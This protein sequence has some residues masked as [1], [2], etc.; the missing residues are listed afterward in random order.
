MGIKRGL[1][2]R[3][4]IVASLK[5]FLTSEAEKLRSEQSEAVSKREE[6]VASVE[7]LIAEMKE[8]L[9]QADTERVLM[10]DESPIRVGERGLG[11][12]EVP[13]LTIG[14]GTREVRVKPVARVVS[15]PLRATAMM[16]VP[17]AYGRVDMTNGLDRYLI[18][19]VEKEA[20][21]RWTIVEQDGP[22]VEPFNRKSF[23]SAFQRLLE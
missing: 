15:A 4:S 18:F 3:R 9:G 1:E 11:T 13:A 23:E 20:A 21:D 16:Q 7:R 19:R 2:N 17:R 12:Y 10:I 5:E 6:W 22:L 8:W 14:L